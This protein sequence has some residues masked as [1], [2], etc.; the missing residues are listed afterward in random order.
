MRYIYNGFIPQNVAP[1]GAERISVYD[2]K[3]NR[4]CGMSLGTLSR[5]TE[6]KLFSFGL[7]SDIHVSAEQTETST[8]FDNALKYFEEQGCLF[9]CHGG[10]MTNIGFWYN[11]D[12]TEIYLGQ[13]AEYK[14]ICDL[15]PNMPVYGICGNHENYNKSITNNLTELQMY[16]GHGLYYTI[17][18]D[19]DLFLFIGQPANSQPTMND[20]EFTW[21][22]NL[23]STNQDKRCHVFTH[24]FVSNDSG[25]T[26]NCYTCYFGSHETEFKEIMASHGKAIHYHGHSHIKLECQEIDKSTNYTE[27]NGF[28]SVHIPSVGESRNVVL[29][30]DGTYKRVTEGLCSQGYIVDVYDDYIIYN[31]ME[32]NSGQLIPTGTFKIDV[33]I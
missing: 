29:Q 11:A 25:S 32:F 4:V 7:I 16:T 17:L 8:H 28:P 19:K 9:C 18:Q 22:K 2:S 31:G 33:A 6:A 13:F 23:L 27:K 26:K 30:A 21:L 3:G 5:P 14:R 15:H 20:E 10:D 1:K 12:D 24:F